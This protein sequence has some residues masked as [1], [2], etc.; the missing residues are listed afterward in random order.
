MYYNILLVLIFV[1]LFFYFELH[2]EIIHIDRPIT[3][4]HLFSVDY[5]TKYITVPKNTYLATCGMFSI[6][7]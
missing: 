1:E 3:S 5:L 4:R 2:D 6:I 7:L